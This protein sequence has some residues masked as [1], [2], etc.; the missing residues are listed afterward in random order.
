MRIVHTWSTD[1]AHQTVKQF[2]V[3]GE[4]TSLSFI[5]SNHLVV[6]S[7]E[8]ICLIVFDLVSNSSIEYY[9]HL[10]R[11]LAFAVAPDR[12]PAASLTW[13]GDLALWYTRTWKERRRI[14][15]SLPFLPNLIH[16]ASVTGAMDSSSDAQTKK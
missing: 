12:N 15:N 6:A 11:L 5:C 14:E 9:D 7:H 2:V 1:A 8:T 13:K 10:R 3:T 16:V 4:V